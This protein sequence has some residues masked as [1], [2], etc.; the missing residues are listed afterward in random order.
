MFAV[1]WQDI[2]INSLLA[3]VIEGALKVRPD[4]IVLGG[5]VPLFGATKW[6]DEKNRDLGGALA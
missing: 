1:K 5:V 4:W 3:D 2:T 6:N